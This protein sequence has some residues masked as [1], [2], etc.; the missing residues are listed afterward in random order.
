MKKPAYH[1]GS[2]LR[3]FGDA[4]LIGHFLY[5]PGIIHIPGRP[6]GFWNLVGFHTRSRKLRKQSLYFRYG[7]IRVEPAVDVLLADDERHP[8]RIIAAVVNFGH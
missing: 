5:Y 7:Q 6:H 1:Y 8:K 2:G 4:G 3:L